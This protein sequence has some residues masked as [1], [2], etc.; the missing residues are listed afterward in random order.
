MF[1]ALERDGMARNDVQWIPIGGPSERRLALVNNRVK[2][3]LL[4][5]DYALVA[6][7]DS[8]VVALDRV[9]RTNPDYPHEV[10]V[11][12][13]ELA[14]KQ[15]EV[16]T[17]V[18]KSIIEACRFIVGPPRAHGRDLQEVHRRDRYQA[19]QR[20]LRRAAGDPRLRR[21]RRHDPQGHG[22]RGQACGAR[23]QIDPARS[24]GRFQIP[25]RGRSPARGRAG[26][27]TA[28][29]WR[30]CGRATRRRC[31]RRLRRHAGGE[32]AGRLDHAADH[33]LRRRRAVS[34]RRGQPRGIRDRAV[35]RRV[36]ERVRLVRADGR[37]RLSDLHLRHHQ[38]Q[39]HLSDPAA[40]RHHAARAARATARN[41]TSRTGFIS[42]R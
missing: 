20:G 21:Q 23:R 26:M 36:P 1:P 42:S 35:L 4:H 10:L 12:R 17:A 2:G 40:D 6:Q 3:A 11:V 15:P 22:G 16:V 8:K 27:T 41:S 9:V 37:V 31:R 7:R 39:L 24:L 29:E 33:A 18:T 14:E 13:K 19:C 32:P 30:R 25:G 38:D 34:P 28:A 5:L